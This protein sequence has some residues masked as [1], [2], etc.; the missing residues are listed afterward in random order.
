MEQPAFSIAKKS[1]RGAFADG[2]IIGEYEIV[3][4]IGK[5]GMGEVYLAQDRR[6]HRRV[7]LKLVRGGL[8]PEA[9]AHRFEREQQL[10]AGLN[11][12]NIAQLYANGVTRDGIPFFAME[13]VEGTRLDQFVKEQALGL[14]AR[15]E[16]FR[17]ICAA[18]AYAHQHLVIHRDIKPAN[19]LVTLRGEP[20]LLDFGIA[21]LLDDLAAD[22]AEQTL[23]MQRI[24]TPEYASPEQIR[25][26]RIST[27]SDIYSLG[28]VLYRL[29]TDATPYRLT[30]RRPDEVARAITEQEPARPST[31]VSEHRKSLRGDLD[32]IALMA[33]RKEPERRYRSVIEFSDDIR[34]HLE[35]LPVRARRGT[36]AYRAT[37]FVRRNRIAVAAGG[38]VALAVLGALIVALIAGESAR[39]QRDMAE[40]ERAKAQRINSFLQRTLAF[41]NQ[42]ITSVSPVAQKKDVTVNQMLDQITPQIDA[43]LAD[44]PEVRAQVL[45]TIGAA[46]ASQGQYGA[47]EKVLRTA[48]D[49]QTRLY[50]EENAE[51]AAT[52]AELGVLRYRQADA[53]QA[54]HLLEKAVGFYRKQQQTNAAG[55]S[56]AKLAHGLDHL[57]VIKFYNGERDVAVS[58]L[59]E[60]SEIAS[61]GNLRGH[62]RGVIASIKTNLG[63]LLVTFGQIDE[64]GALLRESLTEFREVSTQPR[65]EVGVT[66]MYLG[67]AALSKN[68]L[69]EAEQYLLESERLFRS[70][71]GDSNGYLAT[72]L[73]RQAAVLFAKGD[74]N[75]AEEKAR[76]SFAIRQVISPDWKALWIAPMTTLGDIMT[77][78]D[79]ARE[80]ENFYR[81]ALAIHDQ[82][83]PTKNFSGI[84]QLQIRLS[85][86]LMA[87]HRFAEARAIAL[88]AQQVAGEHL[89]PEGPLRTAIADCLAQIGRAEAN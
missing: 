16:L 34:R 46:Y 82:Q 66:Q 45:R 38:L 39:R 8:D 25:G 81:E 42:S 20:K 80:G 2:E 65:W 22:A 85:Y 86:S 64:G 26:E 5:G 47:A 14:R 76:A 6:L 51:A 11:H 31:S 61:R 54:H 33:L 1:P 74:F 19:I 57:A 77:K 4:L 30:S 17:K 40:H 53:E 32:N 88:Q 29:L 27:A 9:M 13:F 79:R 44:Q 7:A 12:P 70:T 37:K 10:L 75:A 55:Y 41:S 62:E 3:S 67:I 87:Q 73:D 59:R 24:L 78:T 36:V 43:E 84:V 23:T 68:R 49:L 83:Q 71:L 56:A 52:M 21:K 89:P 72:N 35:G 15:L 28:V 63:G 58:M 48:L 69:D 18:L 60:A 50:G